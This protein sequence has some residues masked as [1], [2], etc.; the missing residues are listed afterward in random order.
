MEKS[1]KAV[2]NTINNTIIVQCKELENDMTHLKKEN[3]R[4]DG[5]EIE[6]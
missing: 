4:I 5:I 2:E 3:R 6:T 1:L